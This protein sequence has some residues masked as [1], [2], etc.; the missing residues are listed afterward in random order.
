MIPFTWFHHCM[1]KYQINE[2]VSKVV[3]E[4]EVVVGDGFIKS[5]IVC[6]AVGECWALLPPL[7]TS[8]VP[9]VEW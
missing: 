4:G 8:S 9:P 6:A 1:V 3:S 2:S 7:L 5:I